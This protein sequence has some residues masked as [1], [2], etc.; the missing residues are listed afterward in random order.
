MIVLRRVIPVLR[1][2]IPVLP[3][4]RGILVFSMGLMVLG[5]SMCSESDKVEGARP[6]EGPLW[7]P[8]SME[9]SCDD[10]FTMIR[11]PHYFKRIS[12]GFLYEILKNQ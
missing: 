11:L 3:A 9:N 6:P 2:V 10:S 7:Q 12:R 4:P 5:L 8:E 1:C